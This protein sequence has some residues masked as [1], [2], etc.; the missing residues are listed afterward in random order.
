MQQQQIFPMI[1]ANVQKALNGYIQTKQ[2]LEQNDDYI[3]PPALGG[4][5]G[6]LGAI[7]LGYLAVEKA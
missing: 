7:A 3:V 2:V 6:V 1:R 5:A 4:R